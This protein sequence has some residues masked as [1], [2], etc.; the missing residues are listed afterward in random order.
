MESQEKKFEYID[1][2]I[3]WVGYDYWW[4]IIRGCCQIPKCIPLL[5][6]TSCVL[7]LLKNPFE[8][9]FS[10][11]FSSEIW[12]DAKLYFDGFVLKHDRFDERIFDPNLKAGWK[13]VELADDLFISFWKFCWI[14]PLLRASN[15]EVLFLLIAPAC[16]TYRGLVV[17]LLVLKYSINDHGLSLFYVTAFF[18]YFVLN[19]NVKNL[20]C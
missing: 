17:S 14:N 15:L 3:D 4:Q 6:A 16:P 2:Q 1:I 18:T 8:A 10:F 12:A 20:K 13:S 5:L 9:E 11:K 7:L 19:I